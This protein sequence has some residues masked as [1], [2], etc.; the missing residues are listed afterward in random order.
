MGFTAK[1]IKPGFYTL[2]AALVYILYRVD[3]LGHCIERE[4]VLEDHEN[5]AAVTWRRK[6]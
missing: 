2:V 5:L 1:L 4:V 6:R 3:E